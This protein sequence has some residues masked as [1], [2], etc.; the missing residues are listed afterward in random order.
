MS[1]INSFLFTRPILASNSH[2]NNQSGDS[3]SLKKRKHRKAL[4]DYFESTSKIIEEWKKINEE[5]S[6]QIKKEIKERI[7]KATEQFRNNNH[8]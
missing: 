2:T 7:Q 6:E 4:K 3:I 5:D 1:Y 8:E